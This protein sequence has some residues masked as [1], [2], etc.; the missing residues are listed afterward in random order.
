M[1][2]N[3]LEDYNKYNGEISNIINN[4]DYVRV[5]PRDGSFELIKEFK[6][7][8]EYVKVAVRVSTRGDMIARTLYVLNNNRVANF[9][10][11]GSLTKV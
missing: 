9:I 8:N 10:A 11:R 5:N 2:E 7:D 1:Q 4:P 3:H 6:I